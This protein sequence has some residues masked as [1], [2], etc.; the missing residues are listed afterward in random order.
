M[1]TTNLTL[2]KKDIFRFF[3]RKSFTDVQVSNDE[4]D[5]IGKDFM[6][7]LQ[8]KCTAIQLLNFLPK[9]EIEIIM[10]WNHPLKMNGFHPAFVYH[11]TEFI[12]QQ[13]KLHPKTE[14]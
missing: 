1:A 4:C 10:Y 5:A 11:F 8:D 6:I 14:T 9:D 2:W 3:V 12:E 13:K 7:Y